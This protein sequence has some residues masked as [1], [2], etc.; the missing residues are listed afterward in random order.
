MRS[1]TNKQLHSPKIRRIE[2][3]QEQ[4]G[5]RIRVEGY[6]QNERADFIQDKVKDYVLWFTKVGSLE[7]VFGI[8]RLAGFKL[9]LKCLDREEFEPV[10]FGHVFPGEERDIDKLFAAHGTE[11]A[12]LFVKRYKWDD[13]LQHVPEVTYQAVIYVEGDRAKR[14]YNNMIRERIRG[15]T[16]KYK[17]ADRYG[18][19]LCRDFIPIQRVNE[20][21]TGFGTGSNSF[22][23]LHGFVNCQSLKLTAN[24]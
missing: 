24:R 18:I 22:L 17:V 1:L 21:I 10:S 4:T 11:A 9:H 8:D 12:D 13:R 7:Q 15:N 14:N 5:T 19:W 23:L 6:N 2:P 3:Y 20:W 16:G